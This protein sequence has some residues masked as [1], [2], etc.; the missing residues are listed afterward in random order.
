MPLEIREL[1]IKVT[2][3]ESNNPEKNDTR[4]LDQKITEMKNRVV[5]ECIEKIKAGATLIQLYTGFI[6][7]G[8]SLIKEI[9]QR[10][11]KENLN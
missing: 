11:L 1:I 2:V 3:N 5:K 8:P 7:E 6:Y 9:N 4:L 10:L